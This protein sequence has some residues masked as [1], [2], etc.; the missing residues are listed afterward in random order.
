[1]EL[2][3]TKE[4]I[5]SNLEI[6]GTVTARTDAIKLD[7]KKCLKHTGVDVPEAEQTE[8][9]KKL[10]FTITKP[11]SFPRKRESSASDS[12]HTKP[13]TVPTEPQSIIRAT[14]SAQLDS[15][16]RGN[17]E[18]VAL[19]VIPPSWRPDI[20][21]AADLVEEII[22]IKGYDNLP[23]TSLSR[24]DCSAPASAGATA[25]APLP[26][27]QS[28]TQVA[29][30]TEDRRAHAA[31]R[32]LAAQGLMESV[33]W[34]FM[35]SA[36]AAQ[37]GDVNPDLRLVNPI[38]SDL[39]VM[40]PSILGN[41][42]SAAKRNADRGFADV[43]LFEVGP[44]F[45]NPT[46]EGQTI[47]ATALRVG[48]TPRN[49]ATPTRPVDAFDAKSDAL[50]ALTA[51]G[52]PVASLQ[53]TTDAPNWY[54]PGRSG[55]LRLGANILA[56]FGEIHPQVIE[57]CDASGPVVGCEIFLANIP[58]PRSNGTAKPL[59]KLDALQ[60]VSR[61]FAFVVD[62]SVTA[63]K[64]IQAIKA[65][66]KNLIREVALFDVYEGDKIASGKKSLALSV[67]LQPTDKTLTDAEIDALAAK[68]TASVTK[69][70]G[71][72]LRG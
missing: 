67:T 16:L 42:I 38:S 40:R 23:A 48:N 45:K 29:I 1:L 25:T 8:I 54:H 6:A 47:V 66:D 5:V 17:D 30:D 3:G 44:I 11:P 35:S 21:G 46:P 68:I 69:A 10:G 2:C 51:A 41:L 71:A 43:G 70:T 50:A 64:L 63:A 55:V 39:D 49:W 53:I 36:I 13:A 32:A 60:S 9:L 59:L 26:H 56:T 28:V 33:T 34:S 52:A 27:P 12:E 58:A 65:A 18:F 15:R 57:A 37:F 22:R 4:T 61:D 72:V 20:E 14:D 31:R 7:V 24:R 19:S 62:R